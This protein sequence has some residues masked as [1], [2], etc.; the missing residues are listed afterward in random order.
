MSN[1]YATRRQVKDAGRIFGSDLNPVVDRIIE[2]VSRRIDAHVDRTGFIPKTQT[3]YYQWPQGLN[4]EWL[5]EIEKHDLISI[6]TLKTKAQSASPVTIASSDYFLEPVNDGPPY[7]RVEIDLETSALFEQG[8]GPQQAIEIVGE[9]GYQDVQRTVTNGFS[10]ISGNTDVTFVAGGEV[11]V[12]DTVFLTDGVNSQRIFLKENRAVNTAELLDGAVTASVAD[13]VITVDDAS[14]F[15]VNEIIQVGTEKMLVLA[16]DNVNETLTVQRA[17]DGSILAAHADNAIIQDFRTFTVEQGVNGT[18]EATIPSTSA[19]VYEVP[20]DVNQ[21]C[22]EAAVAAFQRE[23]A[24]QGNQTGSGD[25]VTTV[26]DSVIEPALK[27]YRV[28]RRQFA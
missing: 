12:G 10:T 4:I 14:V 13:N 2:A 23:Q 18:T 28:W 20:M 11:E 21:A 8:G 5:L 27:G 1:W 25:S 26:I 15:A 7:S 24:G 19:G 16:I 6:T 17:Y 9:W 3:R 22:I